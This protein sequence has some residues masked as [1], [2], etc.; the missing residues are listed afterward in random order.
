MMIAV[1]LVLL[2]ALALVFFVWLAKS[3]T[4][5]SDP[6]QLA[7]KIRPVDVEAFRNLM[8]PGEEAYLRENLA[9]GDFKAI[10]RERLRAALEYVACVAGNASILMRMGELARHSPEAAVATAGERLVDSAIRLRLAAFQ[11]MAKLSLGILFPSAR[12]FS[13]GVADGYEQMTGLV[14]LLG[15]LQHPRQGVSAAH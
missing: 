14:Y 13:T 15:R 6:E 9:P 5:T 12:S 7:Q 8:D 10:Q 11:A 3:R 2:A 4:A 1:I